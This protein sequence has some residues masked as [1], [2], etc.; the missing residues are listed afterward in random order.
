MSQ[1]IQETAAQGASLTRTCQMT[2]ISRA[3]YYRGLSATE[4]AKLET[5]LREQIQQVALEWS[6]FGMVLLWN[7]LA[8]EWSCFGMVLLWLPPHHHT[9]RPDDV[10]VE[11][12]RHEYRFTY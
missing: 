3:C 5:V 11:F 2:G 7:G 8:L 10:V 4:P 6:C 12:H 9:L 1:A